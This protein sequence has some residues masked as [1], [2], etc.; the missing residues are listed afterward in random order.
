VTAGGWN[1]SQSTPQDKEEEKKGTDKCFPF[2]LVSS[3]PYSIPVVEVANMQTND[4]LEQKK[5]KKTILYFYIDCA[6]MGTKKM[7]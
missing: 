1:E 7:W 3:A 2:R 5:T 4:L 6:L